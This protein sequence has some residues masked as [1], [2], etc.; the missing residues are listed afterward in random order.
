LKHKS[1][2]ENVFYQFQNQVE[3]SLGKKIL[4]VQYD[5]GGEYQKLHH[6]FNDTGIIHR[7]ISVHT[8]TNKMAPLKGNIDT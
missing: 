4:S 3:G 2:V 6:Y 7:I 5:W 1:D 8:P